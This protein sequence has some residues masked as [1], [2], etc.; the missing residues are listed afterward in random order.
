MLSNQPAVG[1]AAD[2]TSPGRGSTPSSDNCR[3]WNCV[4]QLYDDDDLCTL[5]SRLGRER[6]RQVDDNTVF[7]GVELVDWLQ[8]IDKLRHRAAAVD[9]AEQLLSAGYIRQ[10]DYSQ[11][12]H[13]GFKQRR[14]GDFDETKLYFF[15]HL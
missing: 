8:N 11:R 1:S 13:H 7:V 14:Q 6:G 9:Y 4:S 10:V 2:D 12:P 15:G 3:C 5:G